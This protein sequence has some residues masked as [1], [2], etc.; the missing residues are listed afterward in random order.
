[1]I[2]EQYVSFETAKLLKQAGFDEYVC[3]YFYV[4]NEEVN[5][6]SSYYME[7]YNSSIDKN[8]YSRPTQQLAARWLREEH[9]IHISVAPDISSY[10][11]CT[12]VH[13]DRRFILSWSVFKEGKV[14]CR[15]WPDVFK[16]FE[17]ALEAGLQ[18]AL[19]QIIFKLKDK[20]K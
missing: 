16:T 6:A 4:D 12:C 8:V 3:D 20:Q 13:E 18:Q 2:T 7:H 10:E 11:D 17:S 9:D 1:M 14:H 19:K 5:E 15:Y